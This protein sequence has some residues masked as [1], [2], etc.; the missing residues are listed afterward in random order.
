ML[1][2]ILLDSTPI[3]LPGQFRRFQTGLQCCESTRCETLVCHRHC[4]LG[5]CGLVDRLAALCMRGRNI[6]NV[7]EEPLLL[8]VTAIDADEL[9]SL[10]RRRG[11]CTAHTALAPAD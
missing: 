8:Y 10:V 9:P 3:F 6:C 5:I 2:D 4:F 11:L 1:G 7:S